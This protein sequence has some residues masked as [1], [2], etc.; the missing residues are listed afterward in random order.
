MLLHYKFYK[1]IEKFQFV[2]QMKTHSPSILMRHNY[3]RCS[4]ALRLYNRII[5]RAS[6]FLP[7]AFAYIPKIKL[8][9]TIEEHEN[10][11]MHRII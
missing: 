10:I 5:K 3:T 2:E 11:D 8:R 1:E 9:F 4:R 7:D 6:G